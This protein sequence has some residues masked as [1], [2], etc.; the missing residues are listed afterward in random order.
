MFSLYPI[1]CAG[2]RSDF[3]L[4]LSNHSKIKRKRNRTALLKLKAAAASMALILSFQEV[5]PH[6]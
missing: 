3:H 4:P 1:H 6:R 5:A 2:T